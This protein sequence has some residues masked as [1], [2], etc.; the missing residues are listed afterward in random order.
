MGTFLKEADTAKYLGLNFQKS[1]SRNH[2]IDLIAKKANNATSFLQRNI[3]QCPRRTKELC[4]ITLVRPLV[5][6]SSIIWDPFTEANIWKL[7]MV[8]R[9]AARMVF[10]DYRR[11]SS[12]TMI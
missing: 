5:E 4:Y 1:L 2:H 11:T 3:H 7:E 10:S 9:R 12:V 6:Y 8:Q